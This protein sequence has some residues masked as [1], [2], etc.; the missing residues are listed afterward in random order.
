MRSERGLRR[1][2]RLLVDR[3]GNLVTKS[4]RPSRVWGCAVEHDSSLTATI[5]ELRRV[6]KVVP[7]PPRGLRMGR[8]QL[9]AA[10]MRD[11]QRS[12]GR[13]CRLGGLRFGL[14][15]GLLAGLI[16]LAILLVPLNGQVVRAA[17]GSVPGQA[18]HPL[19]LHI[20]RVQL[21]ATDQPDRRVSLSLA[22]VG[23]RAAEI[24]ALVAQDSAIDF[25]ALVE[26]QRL[27]TEVLNA[28]AEVPEPTM[29]ETLR[30]VAVQ[31][32]VHLDT[33]RALEETATPHNA[34]ILSSLVQVCERGQRLATHALSEP[35]QF[36]RAY[37]AGRPGLFLLP[38]EGPLGVVSGIPADASTR[39]REDRL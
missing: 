38:G 28:T 4:D 21:T 5:A 29:E 12:A 34:S 15:D 37:V 17:Q 14:V 20:E 32:Q 6:L 18:L 1:C 30:Y 23:E 11:A 26:M 7:P 25:A 9:L 35:D 8:G 31:L 16:A 33:L 24:Q 39:L 19:K 3:I 36:R 13:R 10:A 22:F 2:W 27:V